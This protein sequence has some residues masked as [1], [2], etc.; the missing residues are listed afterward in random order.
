MRDFYCLYRLFNNK[1]HSA[2]GEAS[3]FS[4]QQYP[5]VYNSMGKKMGTK[6][7]EKLGKKMGKDI[8]YYLGR[9]VLWRNLC[10]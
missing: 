5:L 6:M 4:T 3:L 9:N 8:W 7:G 2:G 10:F 1:W